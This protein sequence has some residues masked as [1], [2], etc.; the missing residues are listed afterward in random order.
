MSA[1]DRNAA[2]RALAAALTERA[3]SLRTAASSVG[4]LRR[5][6]RPFSAELIGSAAVGAAAAN[7]YDNYPNITISGILTNIYNRHILY[8][9]VISFMVF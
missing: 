9:S 5:T 2:A 3:K 1:E 6:I 4:L 8:I 7:V